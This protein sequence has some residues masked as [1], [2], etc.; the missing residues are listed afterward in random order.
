MV[1]PKPPPPCDPYIVAIP[2]NTWTLVAI[3]VDD[4]SIKIADTGPKMYI[5]T[6]VDTG[7]AAPANNDTAIQIP[8]PGL[9]AAECA[10][11]K[12][13]YVKTI[14][15]AGVVIVWPCSLLTHG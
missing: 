10:A 15:A 5:M 4:V 2:A 1:A 8:R 11:T 14:G 6:Q 7:N 12:D 13:F 3:G 9:I